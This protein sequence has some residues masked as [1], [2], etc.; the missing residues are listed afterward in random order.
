MTAAAAI[1]GLEN[2]RHFRAV[3]ADTVILNR[4][5]NFPAGPVFRIGEEAAD[6]DPATLTTI[7]HGIY[8]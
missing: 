1:K 4:D 7:L 5:L 3:D 8:D 2:V 6:T